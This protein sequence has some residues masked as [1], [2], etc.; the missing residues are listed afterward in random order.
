M[1][2]SIDIDADELL[3]SLSSNERRYLYDELHKEFVT[4]PLANTFETASKHASP[5]WVETCLKLL[6]CSV[7]MSV[8]DEETIRS[9]AAKYV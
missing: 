3:A 6:G 1:Y 5:E 4:E 7:Q 9:I 8:E 2:V